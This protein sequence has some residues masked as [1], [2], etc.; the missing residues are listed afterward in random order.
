MSE[1]RPYVSPKRAAQAGIGGQSGKC[2]DVPNASTTNGT[3]LDIWTCNGGTNQQYTL[4]ASGTITVYG[5]KCLDAY[6]GGTAPGTIVD[7]YT[8][9][10]GTNQQ[11]QEQSNGT[12]TNVRSGLCLDVAG[13]GTANGSQVD[14]WTCNGGANQ[15]WAAG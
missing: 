2:L 3:Q 5:D 1:P 9:D 6:Q 8:C 13:Q 4:N 7:I 10:G 14:L 11:W 12:I 15:Q